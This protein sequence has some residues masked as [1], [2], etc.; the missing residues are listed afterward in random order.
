MPTNSNAGSS[1]AS[2]ANVS[3]KAI[4]N[5]TVAEIKAELKA[6]NVHF[7]SKLRKQDLLKLLSESLNLESTTPGNVNEIDKVAGKDAGGDT[8]NTKETPLKWNADHPARALL[9]KEIEAGNIP[10]DANQM[11]PAE[12]HFTCS[13]TIEFQMKGME[14]GDTF[15]SPTTKPS[16]DNF[17]R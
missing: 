9:H 14:Y 4:S 17:Y 1:T 8:E 13:H 2:P 5:L 6:R 12:V 10:L 15:T 7:V 16:R 11:G 3:S